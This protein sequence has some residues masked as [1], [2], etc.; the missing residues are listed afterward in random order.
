[1]NSGKKNFIV[2]FLFAAPALVLF[3]IF[4]V[5]PFISS[6]YYSLTQ[7]D[8]LTKPVFIGLAN[9]KRLFQE[10]SFLMA[11]RNTMLFALAGLLISNVLSL[12]LAL[13]LNT[14]GKSKVILRTIFYL[15]GVVSFVSMSVVW[16]AIYHINGPIN[17]IL[18]EIGWGSLTHEWLGNYDTVL[19]A[20]IAIKV[21]GGV[22]F[23]VIVFLAGLNSVPSELYEAADLDGAGSIAKFKNVTFPLLMPAVTVVT[24]LGLTTS[25][26]VFDLPFVMTKGGPGDA[27]NTLAM[28]IY[29]QAFA[30]G[31]YGYAS[32]GGI[33]LF[34]FVGAISLIQM[35]LTRSRE[36]QI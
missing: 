12:L 19:P 33:I 1:M 9:F 11:L 4:A 31:N 13:A 3:L 16:S 20:L 29:K 15:P 10:E 2:E 35:R 34:L 30:Y 5:W 24:F 18:K 21:W 27:S 26:K 28:I 32:A 22:G 6:L 36:V 8:G 17:Q 23:G 25:L 14:A 7:W